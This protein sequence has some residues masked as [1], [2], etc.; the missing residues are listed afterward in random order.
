[1]P[2]GVWRNLSV[3]PKRHSLE[4][5]WR[6]GTF[7]SGFLTPKKWALLPLK[8]PSKMCAMPAYMILPWSAQLRRWAWLC[9]N[10][11]RYWQRQNLSGSTKNVRCC[12]HRL[13][14]PAMP[15]VRERWE[16]LTEY[17]GN[18][19]FWWI[20][21][22]NSIPAA[23]FISRRLLSACVSSRQEHRTNSHASGDQR[24]FQGVWQ[25]RRARICLSV[26][27]KSTPVMVSHAPGTCPIRTA[28]DQTK[29]RISI[30]EILRLVKIWV[31]NIFELQYEFWIILFLASPAC[32]LHVKV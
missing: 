23:G 32:F 18:G 30:T 21:S 31:M 20:W 15:D 19:A 28:A 3:V 25:V 16:L 11:S 7:L 10:R 22:D 1:M 29:P 12:V 24:N 13:L 26:S 2:T 4:A 17:N 6:S 9:G 5:F 8:K 14:C 27:V